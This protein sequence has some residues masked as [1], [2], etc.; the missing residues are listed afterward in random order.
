MKIPLSRV[1]VRPLVVA[2]SAAVALGGVTG[3]ESG[4]SNER[5]VVTEDT[6]VEID[7]DAVNQAYREAEG[8][9]DFE[10]RVNEI[11]T[12][13]EVI[14]VSVRDEDDKTQVVTGFFDKNGDGSAADGEK[15][16]TIKRDLVGEGA[17]Q[18]QIAGAGPYSHYHSP[19]WDIAAG[20]MLGSFLSNMFMP[21]YRPM[22][23]VPY[24]TS[25]ARAGALAAHRDA[26]RA[27]NPSKFPPKSGASSG[28]SYG[29]RGGAWGS[30]GSGRSSGG[31]GGRRGGG[32]GVKAKRTRVPLRA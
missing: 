21:G 5:W 18:Y 16:F 17:A 2:L 6:R 12:G 22:Y 8:P 26:H 1:A 3:C 9:E 13:D 27:A 20:M 15:I 31:G 10:K 23:M 29:S 4:R 32:F 30:G 28:R 14:S 11:Y 25:P 7:W 19:M 24:S